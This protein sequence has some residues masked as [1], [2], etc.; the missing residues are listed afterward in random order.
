MGMRWG[1]GRVLDNG[2]W[3]LRWSEESGKA[4][5]NPSD[6]CLHVRGGDGEEERKDRDHPLMLITGWVTGWCCMRHEQCLLNDTNTLQMTSRRHECNCYH[7]SKETYSL[8][9]RLCQLLSSAIPRFDLHKIFHANKGGKTSTSCI[10]I[11]TL[12]LLQP[13]SELMTSWC[14]KFKK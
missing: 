10:F 6:K 7:S 5:K 3:W 11:Q 8:L 14:W 12:H 13:G 9:P 4:K 2:S 1:Q